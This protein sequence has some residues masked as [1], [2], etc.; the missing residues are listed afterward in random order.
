MGQ[1]AIAMLAVVPHWFRLLFWPAHLQADYS[2]GEIVAQTVWGP[3]QTLGVLLLAAVI[4]ATLFCR[5]RAPMIAFGLAWCAIALFPVHNVLVPTGIVLAER[6]LFLPSIGAMLALGGLGAVL[7]ERATPRSRMIL[8]AATAALLMLG[9]FRSLTR[10]PVWHDQFGL[11]YRTAN[12]DAPLSFHA[13]EALAEAYFNVGV[14][15]MA[16]EEYQLAMQFAPPGMT[17]PMMQYG[18]KLRQRGYCYPAAQYYRKVIAVHPNHLAARAGLIA[19]TLDLGLYREAALQARLA[20]TYDWQRR[21]FLAALATA[22]SA[23]RVNAPTGT[24]RLAVSAS[25]SLAFYVTV[26]RKK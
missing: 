26:G 7:V 3:G 1:R 25:D 2:P 23:I 19:C 5:R 6:T 9:M 21:A 12:E 16:E 13:H 4:L 20:L 22:D 14:E 11:W 24:V 17:R 10:H 15:R 18:D 8:S